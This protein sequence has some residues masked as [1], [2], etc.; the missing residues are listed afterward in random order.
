M[1]TFFINTSGRVDTSRHAVLFDNIIE[2]NTIR[3]FDYNIEELSVC[4]DEVSEII[5]KNEDISEL[6]NILI[7][8]DIPE[9]NEKALAA[10]K[11]IAFRIEET[12][13]ARLHSK[14]RQANRAIVLFGEN[15]T[16][17][18]EYGIQ[19][20]FMK[21]IKSNIWD[22]FRLPDVD[23]ARKLIADKRAS[24]TRDG[25][26]A[27][28]DFAQAVWDELSKDQ[29]SNS[30]LRNSKFVKDVV[31][32]MAEN[33]WSMDISTADLQD[34]LYHC[35][36]NQEKNV[37]IQTTRWKVAYNH[38]RIND[39]DNNALSRSNY[40][41]LLFAYYY[42][43]SQID[44]KLLEN[45]D[46][47]I[48]SP[49]PEVNWDELARIMKARV[50]ILEKCP[51]R[52]EQ[53]SFSFPK[54][55][56]SLKN[57]DHIIDFT[58]KTPKLT[59]EAKVKKGFTVKKLRSIVNNTISKIKK[60]D[61]DNGHEI[62]KYVSVV[63]ESFNQGKDEMIRR[64]KYKSDQYDIKSDDLTRAYIGKEL[65]EAN[66]VIASHK[67]L[68][69]SAVHIENMI[70]T[71]KERIDYCFDC[72]SKGL[73]IYIF[74]IIFVL[75]FAVPYG[76]IQSD[77]LKT[78]VGRL[79]YFITLGSFCAIYT[80]AYWIF[81]HVYKKRIAA[82]LKELCR[83]FSDAQQE[84]QQCI[85]EYSR[86]IRHDIPLSFLLRLYLIEFE[87]YFEKKTSSPEYMTYHKK[88]LK[89]YTEYIDNTLAE[90]DIQQ[91]GLNSEPY[92]EDELQ[93]DI[94]KDKY[95][96]PMVYTIIDHSCINDCFITGGEKNK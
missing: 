71:A 34:I 96:N 72:L 31:C 82:E 11:M 1:H 83:R 4:A 40:R 54:F 37:H 93:F 79:F 43:V 61:E 7:Y 8:V 69:A 68:S 59:V 90:L 80:A 81:K 39:S 45:H 53:T 67:K 52:V 94:S 14:G 70:R 89:E 47:M 56:I 49:I 3:I 18:R 86:L 16:R 95:E 6:Y 10:E 27:K 24:Y 50:Q 55:N 28:D 91:L 63:T 44:D 85:N 64:V 33:L 42:A 21:K 74:A 29:D 13:F 2:R 46:S 92:M 25:E 73:V 38:I 15:F 48:Y 35:F 30:Y 75:M 78:F 23:A 58:E 84:K 65:D 77:V 9:R 41:V 62:D 19:N 17:D 36:E 87:K 76:V 5:S 26:S 51:R 88:M 57:E 60:L 66:A 22:M 12:L 20:T 32:E